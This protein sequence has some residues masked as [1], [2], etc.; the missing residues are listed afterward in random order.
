MKY[1]NEARTQSIYQR[2]RA[3]TKK[4]QQVQSVFTQ[5]VKKPCSNRNFMLLCSDAE[6]APDGLEK[7]NLINQVCGVIIS[8]GYMG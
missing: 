4:R 2:Q 7:W 8:R 3:G 5:T 1:I 6:V